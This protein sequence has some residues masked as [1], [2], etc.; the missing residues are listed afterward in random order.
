MQESI[1]PLAWNNA[2]RWRFLFLLLGLLLGGT[3]QAATWFVGPD[4]VGSNL[5]GWGTTPAQ[6]LATL[7]YTLSTAANDDTLELL[8]GT[9]TQT[10]PLTI[11]KTLT[12]RGE[13]RQASILLF[14]SNFTA[15][16]NI[17]ALNLWSS[18]CTIEQLTIRRENFLAFGA[19][20]EVPGL[21]RWFPY[22]VEDTTI[23]NCDLV[24]GTRSLLLN[25]RNLIVDN[26]A[27]SGLDALSN[28]TYGQDALHIE[29]TGFKGTVAVNRCWFDG[30][31]AGA[32]GGTRVRRT[33]Q[34]EPRNDETAAGSLLITSNIM[35]NVREPFLWAH[36]R[37]PLTN[38]AVVD[39][40]HNTVDVTE[41]TP[42]TLFAFG[43]GSNGFEYLKFDAL[44]IRNSLFSRISGTAIGRSDYQYGNFARNFPI[45]GFTFENNLLY[46]HPVTAPV[47]SLYVP[48]ATDPGWT[49]GSEFRQTNQ[50]ASLRYDLFTD[51]SP[52]SDTN[53]VDR[54]FALNPQVPSGAAAFGGAADGKNIGAWETPPPEVLISPTNAHFIVWSTVSN[55][56]YRLQQS[57]ALQP[58]AWTSITATIVARNAFLS[59]NIGPPT[60]TSTFYRVI[61]P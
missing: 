40:N 55:V 13:D 52:F 50:P 45:G 10:N 12:L 35:H 39:W 30:T 53:H 44:T 51:P 29:I 27:F 43:S 22:Y 48:M 60:A 26:C 2:P 19:V 16:Q 49:R 8:A 47:D 54:N 28:S 21:H 42:F 6:P 59:T 61:T 9:H 25:P 33:F 17:H 11:Q 34:V 37:Y 32:L 23:R 46:L 20:I 36:Y 15:A 3:A 31:L 38:K 14:P 7:E 57:P 1:K 4:G 18:G 56:P 24:G 41:K 5:P 58:A